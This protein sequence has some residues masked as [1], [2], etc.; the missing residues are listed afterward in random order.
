MK[1]VK[2]KIF[3]G[4]FIIILL[5]IGLF[6][7][8][9]W[10]TLNFSYSTGDRAGWVQKF[11]HKGW[12]VKTWEGELQMISMPGAAPEKF[13]FSVRS[14]AVA[15]DINKALGKKVAL[16]YEQHKGVPTQ[17]FGETEYFV[18]AVRVI[19]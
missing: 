16:N 8:Y 9:C 2:S 17:W 4:S 3:F 1:S 15:Q 19:E 7:G 13:L 14:E 6:A 18:T 12:L 11:S 5:G 10:L